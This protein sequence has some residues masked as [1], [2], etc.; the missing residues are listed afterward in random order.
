MFGKAKK[1]RA[2]LRDELSSLRERLDE[3]Q[4]ELA[5]LREPKEERKKDPDAMSEGEMLNKWYMGEKGD[6]F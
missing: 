4:E 5:A 1:E 2:E 3:M 6:G